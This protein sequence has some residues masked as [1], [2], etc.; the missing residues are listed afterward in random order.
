MPTG[1]AFPL[2]R[3]P[4]TLAAGNSR[5]IG[6]DGAAVNKRTSPVHATLFSS[7]NLVAML[8]WLVLAAAPLMPRHRERLWRLAGLWTPLLMS[9]GYL[10]LVASVWGRIDGGF[11]SIAAVRTLFQ[12]DTMLL[13]GWV[14][15]LAFDLFVGGWIVRAAREAGMAHLAVLPL[16]PVTL[17]FG[18]VG[19]LLFVA[20]R[21]VW[22]KAQRAVVT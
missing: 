2:E 15:Y 10:V 12:N 20:L 7:A 8:C 13:A 6:I 1:R 18:P 14:H 11:G 5:A 22:P 21:A 3:D 9:A 16:L 4:R 19:F 17:L